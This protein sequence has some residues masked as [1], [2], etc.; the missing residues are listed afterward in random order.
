MAI[1]TR[2]ASFDLHLAGK[3]ANDRVRD[4]I[5]VA[6]GRGDAATGA[7]VFTDSNRDF[8]A[9]GITTS[10]KIQILDGGGNIQREELITAVGTTTVDVAGGNFDTTAKNLRYKVF[11]PPT[12]TETI[13]DPAKRGIGL[14]GWQEMLDNIEAAMGGTFLAGVVDVTYS[15]GLTQQVVTYD[16]T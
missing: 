16:D 1:Q 11:L 12:A 13:D 6:R 8:S 2:F 14:V 4:Q 9:D 3:S 10:H 7:A 15:E 5:L